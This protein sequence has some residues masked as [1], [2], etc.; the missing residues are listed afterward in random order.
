MISSRIKRNPQLFRRFTGLEVAK[1]DELLVKL[2]DIYAS[3]E[4]KRLKTTRQRKLGGGSQFTLTLEDR[5]IMLL[6]YYKIY[7]THEFLGILFDLDESNIG[8]NI[9]HLNP[10]LAQIFKVPERKIKLSADDQDELLKFFIDG[11]EQPI[12]RPKKQQKKSYSGKKKRHTIKWQIATRDGKK[13]EAVS[14]SHPGKTHDKKMYDKTRLELP[15][16][17]RGVGDTGYVGTNLVQPKKKKKGKKLS[18]AQKK[19]NS[20][21]SR[22]RIKAEHAIAKMK[23]FRISRDQFRNPL[24]THNLF[25]KNVAGLINF[26]N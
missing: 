7:I 12:N 13:I 9:R 5:L 15:P 11:T 8:R 18:K 16:D 26:A 6:L 4:Q 23:H 14:K 22:L 24:N 2:E 20:K 19:Y 1:F 3:N 10:L 21:I 17:S 25:I